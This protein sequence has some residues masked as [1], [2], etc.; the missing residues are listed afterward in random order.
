MKKTTLL[1]N[2]IALALLISSNAAQAQ[3]G[4][5]LQK[6]KDKA[7]Q[8]A[9]DAIDKKTS[10]SQNQTITKSNKATIGWLY[11]LKAPS[12]PSL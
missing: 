3:F 7:A 1:F 5:L 6:A 10:T 9:S 2:L 4:G 8:K 12:W 11:C